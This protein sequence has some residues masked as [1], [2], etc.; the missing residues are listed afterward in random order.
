MINFLH[1][2]DKE[3][4]NGG[5]P[6][7]LSS[8]PWKKILLGAAAFLGALFLIF[9][10]YFWYLISTT[11]DIDTITVSPTESATY[12]C[13]QE[14]N[15]LRKL[16]LASSNRDIVS[17]EDIPDSLQKAVIS[18][19]DQRFY[20]HG[21][22]DI[23]GILRA[24]FS[25]ITKGSFD[26]GASTITQ[27]L[28]KNNVFT[29]WTQENSF[30]DRFSRKVQEQN[31]ALRLEDRMTKDEILENYLNTIN[32]GAGCYGVQAASRR[33]FGKDAGE[34]TLSESAV[35]AAIPQNPTGYNPITYPEA[36][37][38]RQLLILD[39][40]EE[41]GYIS[42][43]EREE[44]AADNVYERILAYDASYQEEDVYSYYEDALIDQVLEFLEDQGYSSE[45]AY[46]A[47]YSGGLRIFSAQD[48]ALQQICDEEFSNPANFPEGTEFGIDYALSVA[49][50]TGLVT[51]YGSEALRGFVRENYDSTFDLLCASEET[52]QMYADAFR[53][54]I[55]GGASDEE[56]DSS[57]GRLN[58]SDGSS[59]DQETDSDD[60]SV[61]RTDDS[62]N[63]AAGRTGVSGGDA[64]EEG[65]ALDEEED[66]EKLTLL[67]ERLT[68]SPQPQ[69]S[70]VLM[71]QYTGYVRALVGGRGE[72]QASLTL[73]RATQT[74]RQPGSTF[75]L[76]T[77]YAPALDVSG[78]TLI[79]QY[80][81][82]P[83]FYEDGTQ[84]SNWD[85]TDYTGLTTIREA[86][87]RSVNVVA[88]KCITEITPQ[89]GFDY[90]RR[91][92]ITTLHETYESGG[93]ISSDVI[94]PL[95]LGGITQGVTNLELCGAYAAIA[96][97]G[98]YRTPKFF[99][100]ILD[101]HGKVI[102][103]Y[104][105]EATAETDQAPN[106]L[107]IAESKTALSS[108][109]DTVILPLQ[110]STESIPAL[111]H[112]TLSAQGRPKDGTRVIQDSTAFLL[113]S[114][115]EDVITSP[116]GTAYGSIRA[117]GQPAAGKTGTTSSYKDIWF[118]GYTPYY[119]CGVWGGYDNNQSLPGGSIFHTYQKALWSA[120]MNRVHLD[121]PPAQFAQPD[122]VVSVRLCRESLL[123]A[124]EDG[125]PDTYVEYF[126]S[127]TEPEGQCPLHQPLPET[128]P[129]QIYPD[130]LDQLLTDTEIATESE[131]ETH[132]DSDSETIPGTEVSPLPGQLPPQTVPD[133]PE[134]PATPDQP[135]TSDNPEQTESS[136][137]PDQSESS[138]NPE[139]NAPGQNPFESSPWQ[140]DTNSLQDLIDR[141]GSSG[142]F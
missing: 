34:L 51:H 106:I 86:I 28:I 71:D 1:R 31:L 70:L 40:M 135:E 79:T 54:S 20:Q 29:E 2:P 42:S 26:Q 84:V 66:S 139:Q 23:R 64:S 82:E 92:G 55:L 53:R 118:T 35:L 102:I 120:V 97:G 6:Y 12:I 122:S 140:S 57:V 132:S 103:D 116:S 56:E 91:F 27:Q 61:G 65:D 4:A 133:Q 123:P 130:V 119:T 127:G 134:S 96:N 33:Y 131:S 5:G 121:L 41:Q 98:I 25:G 129:I 15:Y 94:Q 75:K 37:Q 8:L 48:P 101:R 69:A 50:G 105:Q 89:L 112:T 125:C 87:T 59:K 109:L 107:Q 45:Q 99:T 126:T 108:L 14:G 73:N 76:L 142:A 49:D 58:V 38:K 17:L 67:G 39:Y 136:S 100:K 110:D 32:L 74:T 36:N 93:N 47:V 21:G 113:T 18:I 81:N 30:L 52:A 7:Q 117:G 128:E 90:A 95:A 24:F 114:A 141:L 46:R 13:D 72:K 115:M 83:Y 16:T 10:I 111:S 19:E 78:Q 9:V 124:V 104:T 62:D 77:A 63:N 85:I 88:V 68:L 60:S 44:A 3:D 11:P 138:N 22:I 137:N 43:K 80:D